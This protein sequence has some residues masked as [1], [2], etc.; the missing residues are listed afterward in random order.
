MSRVW[1]RYGFPEPF[2]VELVGAVLRQG[3]FIDKM[4]DM[5]WLQAGRFDTN[6]FLPTR[7]IGRYHA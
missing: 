3:S 7:S 5:G 2:G 4:A 6:V 1:S